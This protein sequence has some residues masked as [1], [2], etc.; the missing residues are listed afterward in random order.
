MAEKLEFERKFL[1]LKQ[2]VLKADVVYRVE[3]HYFGDDRIRRTSTE[4]ENDVFYHTIKKNLRPGVNSENEKKISRSDYYNLLEKSKS[5]II[6][7][8][9]CYFIGDLKWEVDVFEDISL[10][11]AEV[12]YPKEDY[13]IKIP[14][15]IEDVMIM[16][17][18]N[19][20][21]FSNK[22]ISKKRITY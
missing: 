18:T 10:V 1:L 21:E 13:K 3:Q 14:K 8:R 19:F 4:G 9:H 16:E 7:H 6:K 11:V 22:S 5:F 2:P 12:E 20:R 17:V 15:F